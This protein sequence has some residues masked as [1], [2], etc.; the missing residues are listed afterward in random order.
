MALP[1]VAKSGKMQIFL[2]TDATPPVYAAPCGLTTKGAVLNKNLQEVTI[3]DCDDP[4]APSWVARS[5]QSLSVTINGD[6]LAAG[7]S[8]PDWNS[9][10]ISTDAVPMKVEI[11]F[12]GI[13]KKVLE[14]KFL[15]DSLTF[16]AEQGGHVTLGISAQSD[17][18]VLDTWTAAP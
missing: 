11:D 2:G 10:A 5:V 18:E 6:G 13:G 17:G 15:I 12:E 14:G 9:A 3:P 4:D 16:G 8:V 1:S 7:E